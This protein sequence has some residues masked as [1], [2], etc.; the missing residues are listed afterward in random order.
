MKIEV[1]GGVSDERFVYRVGGNVARTVVSA[2]LEDG[3]VTIEDTATPARVGDLFLTQGGEEVVI[4]AVPDA[5]H[6][7][8]ASSAPPANGT[9]FYILRRR[10]QRVDEDGTQLVSLTL[11]EVT[12]VDFAQV[13]GSITTSA[14]TQLIATLS[15]EVNEIQIYNGTGK[16]LKLGTGAP[17]SEVQVAVVP[18]GVVSNIKILLATG[19]RLSLQAIE[20]S[21]SGV[22]AAN[23]FGEV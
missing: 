22:V 21:A 19:T 15:D 7:V 11:P 9:S 8:I 3:L 6:F 16:T 2:V 14:W 1:N 18:F 5:N 23:F 13:S 12:T 10:T 4:V 17:A 20:G